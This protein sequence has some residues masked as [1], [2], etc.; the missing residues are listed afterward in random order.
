M[1]DKSEPVPPAMVRA[2][3]A[4]KII[5]ES[6]EKGALDKCK[7][8]DPLACTR[9]S[10]LYLESNQSLKAAKIIQ[11]CCKQT[12]HPDCCWESGLLHMTGLAN[13]TQSFERALDD[14]QLAAD[15]TSKKKDYFE[16]KGTLSTMY[17]IIYS[18]IGKALDALAQILIREAQV[19][20]ENASHESIPKIKDLESKYK[21]KNLLMDG[22]SIGNWESCNT[23]SVFAFD[24]SFGVT[25]DHVFGIAMAKKS[26][27]VGQEAKA[28]LNLS[29][30]YKQGLLG[31]LKDE[32][33][34]NEYEDKYKNIIQARLQFISPPS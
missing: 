34:A 1:S 31:Q 6:M 23:Y 17:S 14:W 4:V 22:C 25:Q 26:C 13:V 9:L 20:E 27:D 21:L 3:N 2:E 32:R 7:D 12:R 11:D 19:K 24:G 5:L 28:C 33:L 15:Y 10:K 8:G 30:I 29:N 18:I 16:S